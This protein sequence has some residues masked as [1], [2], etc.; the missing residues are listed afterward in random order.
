MFKTLL[1]APQSWF[2][3]VAMQCNVRSWDSLLFRLQGSLKN[4]KNALTIVCRYITV[5]CKSLQS[6][7][8]HCKY[9]MFKLKGCSCYRCY[10]ERKAFF[11]S[12]DKWWIKKNNLAANGKLTANLI[13]PFWQITSLLERW[14]CWIV[15][16][17][18]KLRFS[19]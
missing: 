10:T 1:Y 4:D 13:R 5:F 14:Q 19:V 3:D 16:S 7:L 2:Q 12:T 15:V 8:F 18:R 17:D 9:P 11:L 6:P